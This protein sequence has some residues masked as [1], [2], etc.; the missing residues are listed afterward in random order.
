VLVTLFFI[1]FRI[2]SYGFIAPGDARRH[3]A[4]AF[5]DKS[6][7]EIIVMRPEYK[8]D[9]SPGW[10]WLLR[11]LHKK[12]GWQSDGLMSFSVISMM[13]CVFVAPLAWIRRPEAWLAALMAEMLAIPDL[14]NRFVQA[15]PYLLTEGILIA[16]LFTWSLGKEESKPSNKKLALTALGI[17][18]SVWLH[19]A[20]YLWALP[21][22]AF[23][24]ARRL[25]TGLWFASCVG[26]GVVIGAALTGYPIVFLQQALAIAG[27]VSREQVSQWLLVGELRP[28]YG[29]FPTAVLVALVMLWQRQQGRSATAY[30]PAFW[31]ILLA[32][33]LGFKADRFWAD[34]GIPAVLVWLTLRIEAA[35]TNKWEY[36]NWRRAAVACLVAAPLFLHATNDLDRRYTGCL[37]EAFLDSKEPLL[38][39]WMPEP[40]GIFYTAHL[41]SFYNT[42][43]RNPNGNW[44]YILGMEPALMPDEDLQ[45]YRGIER[46]QFAF[47]AYEPWVAKMKRGDRLV[48][49]C[50]TEPAL[51][52]LE[53]ISA[54]GGIW[55]GRLPQL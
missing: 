10:E 20:W 31:L 14:M 19:G 54:G 48:V 35:T 32:W 34:W 6:Y 11:F 2:I 21:L 25:R 28:S 3:V 40:D 55:I 24:M 39:G 47:K 30:D 22:A 13:C 33:I 45:I 16:V 41:E 52:Q 53:W 23:F 44:R 37:N 4:K 15:R 43:Y 27:A 29:E 18:L 1:P 8:M 51:P 36:T 17:A 7:S 26:T 12:L 38:T 42:F 50:A 9:H 5:T 49:P 46:N